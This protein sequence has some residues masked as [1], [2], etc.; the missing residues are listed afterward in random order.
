[1]SSLTEGA[2]QIC[3]RRPS[4]VSR[5]PGALLKSIVQSESVESAGQQKKK[6]S[7]PTGYRG[8]SLC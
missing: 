8:G 6:A 7:V 5:T 4:S 3:R 1:M 2:T